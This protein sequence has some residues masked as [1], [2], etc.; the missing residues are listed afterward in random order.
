MGAYK[1]LRTS[2]R[3]VSISFYSDVGAFHHRD[4]L[5]LPAVR[6][7]SAQQITQLRMFYFYQKRLLYGANTKPLIAFPSTP[8]TSPSP[9]ASPIAPFSTP[10]KALTTTCPLC[11]LA[12]ISAK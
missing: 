10:S 7:F 1:D 3:K 4:A 12:I 8:Y 5:Y 11:S 2:P 9:Y 6:T